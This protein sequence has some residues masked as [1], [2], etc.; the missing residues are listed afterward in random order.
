MEPTDYRYTMRVYKV[1]K[2][3]KKQNKQKTKQNKT[4]TKTGDSLKI[5][6]LQIFSQFL[7]LH[8]EY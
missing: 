1:A 3:N 6:Y 5:P 4:K 8:S 7:L 2:Q